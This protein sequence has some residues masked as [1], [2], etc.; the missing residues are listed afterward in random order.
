MHVSRV[1]EQPSILVDAWSC[2]TRLSGAVGR[3]SPPKASH[4]HARRLHDATKR[5][6]SFERELQAP[7]TFQR[8]VLSAHASGL[9]PSSRKS[10]GMLAKSR[11]WGNCCLSRG[12]DLA[13]LCLLLFSFEVA[14][15]DSFLEEIL[16]IRGGSSPPICHFIC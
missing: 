3:G 8:A 5:T 16:T 10:V 2:F 12:K 15:S 6:V 1:A 9:H 7:G 11:V 14:D 4:R 13:P